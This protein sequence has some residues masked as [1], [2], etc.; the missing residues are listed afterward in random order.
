MA[1]RVIVLQW[2]TEF[3]IA[4]ISEKVLRRLTQAISSSTREAIAASVEVN[5]V[6]QSNAIAF[7]VVGFA[8][9]VS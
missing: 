9:I 3:A 7:K 2:L 6:N 5:H 8:M 4:P 1:G